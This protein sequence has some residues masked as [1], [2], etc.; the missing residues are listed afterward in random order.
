LPGHARVA[1]PENP[2]RTNWPGY[3]AVTSP[4]PASPGSGPGAVFVTWTRRARYQRGDTIA[5]DL[6]RLGEVAE[7]SLAIQGAVEEAVL[8]LLGSGRAPRDENR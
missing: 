5:D 8:N 4:A 7:G 6:D 3:A 2:R 1:I